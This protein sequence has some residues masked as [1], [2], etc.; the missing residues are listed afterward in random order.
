MT[1]LIL[2][3]VRDNR[4]Y[5]LKCRFKID[6]HPGRARLND[7]KVRVAEMFVRDMRKQGWEHD[8]RYD[9]FTMKGPFPMVTT[10]TL[11][12]RRS[13]TAR[14]MAPSVASGARFLDNAGSGVLEVPPLALSEYWEYEIAGIFVRP[15]IMTEYPDPH[16]EDR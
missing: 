8:A 15:Q 6:P 14:E 16:E 11:H 3:Q 1:T 7:E 5:R 12:S 13:P 10:T 9:D 2:K 4:P